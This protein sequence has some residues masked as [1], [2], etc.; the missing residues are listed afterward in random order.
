MK[1]TMTQE[2]NP[3]VPPKQTPIN[4]PE[5]RSGDRPKKLRI[6]NENGSVIEGDAPTTNAGHGDRRPVPEFTDPPRSETEKAKT[7]EF[8]NFKQEKEQKEL[9]EVV[10]GGLRTMQDLVGSSSVVEVV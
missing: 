3:P 7:K 1:N 8:G 4:E 10:I 9:R 5:H 6:A 2:N